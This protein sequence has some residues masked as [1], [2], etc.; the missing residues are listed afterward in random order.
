MANGFLP[1][2][3]T[4]MPEEWFKTLIKEEYEGLTAH[5]AGWNSLKAI[6]YLTEKWRTGFF[7]IT[8]ILGLDYHI[9]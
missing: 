7:N 2:N 5:T 9:Y 8:A 4:E 1:T 3:Q 6:N